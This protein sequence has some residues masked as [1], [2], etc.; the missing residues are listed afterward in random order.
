MCGSSCQISHVVDVFANVWSSAISKNPVRVATAVTVGAKT[1]CRAMVVFI[2]TTIRRG[3][4]GQKAKAC[5]VFIA[6][7]RGHPWR[8]ESAGPRTEDADSTSPRR[9]RLFYRAPGQPSRS[10]REDSRSQFDR[11]LDVGNHPRRRDDDDRVTPLAP[12]AISTDP[13]R[14]DPALLEAVTAERMH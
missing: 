4:H 7:L 10:R 6:E 3:V 8:V 9:W 14:P 2:R 1:L 11:L 12:P 5:G 13:I